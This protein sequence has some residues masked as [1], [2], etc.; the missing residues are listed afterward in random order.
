MEQFANEAGANLDGAINSSVTSIT[1][2]TEVNVPASGTF[3]ARIDDEILEVTAVSGTTWT[4]TRADGGTTAASHLDDA[5]ITLI[6]TAEAV[7]ALVSIQAAG[8]ETSNRRVLNF[9]NATVADNSGS[10][11]CDITIPASQTLEATWTAPPSTGSW[12]GVNMGSTGSFGTFSSVGP[13]VFLRA[14]Q[15]SSDWGD[16]VRMQ[17]IAFSGNSTLIARVEPFITGQNYQ[18]VGVG[19]YDSS[20]GKFSSIRFTD[21]NDGGLQ[22]DKWTSTSSYSAAYLSLP[23]SQEVKWTWVKLQDDGTYRN[24]SVSCDG[25]NWIKIYQVSRTDF[26]TAN[27]FC[28]WADA[29]N[30]NGSTPFDCGILVASWHITSP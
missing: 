15:Q 29:N 16:I 18:S 28:I 1:V 21:N 4:V 12:T 2:K 3:R 19:F 8:T 14:T 17:Y 26:F 5:T 13:G 9:I 30:H 20:G 24:Y 10:N 11:R 25:N 27:S 6:V 22:V 7:N 23:P